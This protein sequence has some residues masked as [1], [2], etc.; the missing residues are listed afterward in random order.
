V[1]GKLD[2]DDGGGDGGGRNKINDD[3]AWDVG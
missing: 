3:V 1:T 2:G